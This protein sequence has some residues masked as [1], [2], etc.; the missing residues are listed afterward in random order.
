MNI[1]C[2][3]SDLTPKALSVY[4]RTKK[5]RLLEEVLQIQVQVRIVATEHLR[6]VA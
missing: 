3:L 6:V 4:G 1:T 5:Y 2:C